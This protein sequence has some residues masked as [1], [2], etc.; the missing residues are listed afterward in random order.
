MESKLGIQQGLDD[1]ISKGFGEVVALWF[2]AAARLNDRLSE[3]AIR[4]SPLQCS[5]YSAFQQQ[6]WRVG[7]AILFSSKLVGNTMESQDGSDRLCHAGH[8]TPG[9]P[10]LKL[11]RWLF[12]SIAVL[13]L[14]MGAYLMRSCVTLWLCERGFATPVV[15]AL[16]KGLPA[17]TKCGSVTLLDAA[18]MSGDV[19]LVRVV[20]AAGADVNRRNRGGFTPL[21]GAAAT[22]Q[23][24]VVKVLLAAGADASARPSPDTSLLLA[25]VHNGFENTVRLLI[26]AGA[27]VHRDSGQLLA[28]AV[29]TH[30]DSILEMLLTAGADP[31]ARTERGATPL[32]WA[33]AFGDRASVRKLLSYKANAALRDD[34][35]RTASDWALR[36]G[37]QEIADM[38][39]SR[40]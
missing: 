35:G 21:M 11:R 24:A 38:L 10:A 20:T 30:N 17:N 39:T 27:D 9:I 4:V 8:P 31:N 2:R 23:D 6:P 25:P 7:I 40:D 12:T 18:V 5:D 22:G 36:E 33:S 28:E 13:V 32:M 26:H 15:F 37:R 1:C 3:S 19:E 34:D 29:R 14:V 16:K